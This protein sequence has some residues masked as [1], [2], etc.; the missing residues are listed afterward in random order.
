MQRVWIW[1]SATAPQTSFLE[2]VTV[3]ED[4]SFV[5]EDVDVSTLADGELTVTATYTDA[6]NNTATATDVVQKDTTYGE[7]DNGDGSIVQPTVS[8]TDNSGAVAGNDVELISG[9]EQATIRG[10]IGD[11]DAAR[12]D[13]IISDGTTQIELNNV[14]VNADGTFV[15]EDVNVSTLAD[16]ELTVTATY[17]DADNNTATATDVVQKD[18][19]YG[20]DDNGDNVIVQP[21]V[22]ITDNSG[23]VDDN[24]VE[25]ISGTEQATIRGTIG[26]T[27]AARVD[28]VISDGTTDIVLED[29]AVS[30]DGSFVVEDV[31]VS[32]LSDGELTVTAT[33][34]DADNNT[35][36]ATDV[37]QKDTT[38]GE[39]DNG[40]NVIVQP[41]VSI[42]DNSGDV[43]GNDVELISGTEQ[44]TIRGTIGDTDAARVDLVISDGTTDIVLEDVAVN[45]DG[46][47]VVEDVNVSTLADGEL[48]VTATYT[49]ADNNTATATD[50]VQKD[51]TY[52]EDDNGDNVIVQ[53]TV[54][55]TDNS[56]D[57]DG[58][59]VELISGTEQ[60]T[61]R[62]T[63]GDTDAARVDLLISDGTTQIELN[64][65]AVNADGTFVVEDVNVSALA[66]GELTVTATYTD[67]DNN[68]ATATDV[69][70]KDTTYGEDDNGD[71]VIVQ[72]TVSITD[73]SSDVDGND[74]ELISGTEQ[75]TIR[76]T[77]GDTDAARVDL[78]ISD[79][80]IDI[81]LEDVAV[82]EDGSFVV[83]DVN[84]STLADGELTVTATYTDADNNTATA[85]DVVQKDTAYGEDD[86]GDNVIVQPTVSITDNS[87]DVDGNDVELISGT[88]QAT[89]RGTIGDTDAARVDLVISDGTTD[90]VLEDVAVNADGT[91]VVEDVNVSTLAD[92]EL[93]VTAT[94]TDA[95]NNTAT[96]TDVVQKD[97]TYGEDGNDEGSIVQ[98]TVSITDNSGDVDGN[99]VE[100]IS[101]TEQATIRGTIGD[102]DAARVDLVI[103][104]GTTQVELNNVAVNADGTF[105]V[106][107]VNVSTLADGELTVT[108]TYTDADNNTATATDV[109]QKDTTYGEDDNG[110][111][112][113]VQPTVSITDNSGDVDGNDV[114]LI[115]GTE[116]ATI[117][118]TIGDT[119]AARVDL[120]ISDGT[121]DIVL[122]DVAV[123]E[124]GT[125]LV[126][127]VDVSTLA[128]GELTVTA[129]YTDADNNTAT[130]TDVVQ[131]DTTYGEDDNG[132][133]VIVQPTVSIT[134]NSGDV[135]GN[136]VE[137][138]SG[139]EQ[140]TI[141]GTI[142]D[143][144]AARVDLVI[145]DGT[146]QIVLEN[147][148]VSEDG[149]FVVEDVDVSTLADGELTV[150][151]TFT[152]E[153][154]NVA[155]AE[156]TVQ[157]DTTYGEDDNGDNVIVQPT[158]SITDN[159]GDVDGN[160][161]ELI[162]GS[163]QATIRGTIGETD[164]A[165]VDLVISDGTNQIV[166]ENVTVSEDGTFM[167]EDVDVSSLSDGELTVTATFTDEDDNVV[168]ADDTVQK[169]TTYGEDDNGDNVIVQP[170]V[171]ITDNSGDV[172]GNDVE[173]ISGT[174]QATIRGTI[175][176]TDAARVD[177]I[178]SDGTTD[179]V[180]EDVAVSEDGTFV[181]E[182]VDVSSLSDGELTVTA[183]FTDE[184]DNVVTADDTV[185]KDTT[186]GEDDNG[187]NVIVQPTVSITDNSGDVDGNDVELISGTE[188]ATI[189]GTIGD[190]DAARV[191]LVIS[192]G[193]TQIELNNVAVNAD[194]TFVVEDVDVSTLADG[195]LTV[196]ATYTDAD[197]NTA[198]ATDVVQKDTT[199]GEDGNDDGSI[200][201][202]TVSITDNSGDVDG[203]DAETHQRHRAGDHSWHH[204]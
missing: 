14:A 146:N 53:P 108:A 103:S 191:D 106:E 181:V 160:D 30:E 19:T 176:D 75:A 126:E 16:G 29:V 132:D 51:T 140:A 102:T 18:T 136:D 81:V 171:S 189:R 143:T 141:R 185:Q 37:V 164:A 88:E 186:Y 22:S 2:D 130:A 90:I 148:T 172:D 79:G 20:E 71:N 100:L 94:Y 178:I 169:D 34:M 180:L 23:D 83:E 121:T 84:V 89:I 131:K 52:G 61:I 9:T 202:P 74:V 85:T 139:T 73:N 154:D 72:P 43:D 63:I 11:T 50:V 58:N 165:R 33:Y 199:Y 97:T 38:Y 166:L 111:N 163:E 194:G 156:D 59:D 204:R 168:T 123:S 36:T 149:T 68:T 158:V 195:E 203:N 188:Q 157:K 193:T 101:G 57:V 128:D 46:T 135:D 184:D 47:F 151:A 4:G 62:G 5:V 96:A 25:L 109:V 41:T 150:T 107:D 39:D 65:V 66:D 1:S 196:T 99:D 179:I 104:D 177:L 13:L 69:V 122:E 80:T 138:I 159:S 174:E 77:I 170:T 129:T 175:G 167:V 117:R 70:Q 45:A 162:S 105:V 48:T 24:D 118:G 161:A 54:S 56:G 197:N 93:T 17:M 15:V 67:A 92:G 12:V 32:S 134:D 35:A 82:S 8:I 113:I 21:T 183:T 147:V 112:V 137:L 64:N 152:D 87:G 142:G 182:D 110:D 27:D 10:T 145:S 190:T 198:T 119:D 120:V 116:Q 86:N 55:I 124:D 7:D 40:D 173:L 187:D 76:G 78:V 114:E 200:V 127:D 153:D 98:P 115:S 60:A 144:D 42:T 49:D 95:D 91:F 26:D 133:N 125:F 28:L 155:T 6:D 31:N 3:S 201:Q 192:D 44:A